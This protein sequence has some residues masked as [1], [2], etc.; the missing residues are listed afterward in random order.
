MQ[1]LTSY[2]CISNHDEDV[3]LWEVGELGRVG[4]AHEQGVG[5]LAGRARQAPHLLRRPQE[6]RHSQR[7]HH[8]ACRALPSVKIASWYYAFLPLSQTILMVLNVSQTCL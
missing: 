4:L 3:D 5:P 6:A 2:R 7:P 1:K 8:H